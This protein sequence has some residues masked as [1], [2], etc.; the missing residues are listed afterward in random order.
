MTRKAVRPRNWHEAPQLYVIESEC[1]DRAAN[2]CAV[3][4][5]HNLAHANLLLCTSG[6]LHSR[7]ADVFMSLF[8]PRSAC[9]STN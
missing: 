3:A 8:A 6:R 7:I 4:A 5:V 2:E 1:N 9:A